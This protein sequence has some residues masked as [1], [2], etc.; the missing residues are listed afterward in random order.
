MH[1]LPDE[2]ALT[3][4]PT[5]HAAFSRNDGN[6]STQSDDQIARAYTSASV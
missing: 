3:P 4:V 6:W 1:I 5:S 2:P